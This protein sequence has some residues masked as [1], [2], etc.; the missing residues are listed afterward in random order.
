MKTEITMKNS[1]YTGNTWLYFFP[2]QLG[3][4]KPEFIIEINYYNK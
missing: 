1:M 3:P 4:I 2:L